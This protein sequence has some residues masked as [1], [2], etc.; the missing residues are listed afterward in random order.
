MILAVVDRI[1]SGIA[2][3]EFEGGSVLMVPVEELPPA[4]AEG[5]LIRLRFEKAP[6]AI[7][8]ERRR[9]AV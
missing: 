9:R 6:V 4:V 5:E 2:V 3:L 7:A 1:E 8:E